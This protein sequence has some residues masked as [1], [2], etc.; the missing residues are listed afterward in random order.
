MRNSTL[1]GFVLM[2]SLTCIGCTS[3]SVSD[4]LVLI[5]QEQKRA[6]AQRINKEVLMNIQALRSSHKVAMHTYT[7]VYDLDNKE[8][9]HGDKITIA[10]LLE[11][12]HHATINIAPAKGA[13]KLKQLSLSMERAKAL[14]QYISYFN[15]EVTIIFSPKL[16]TDT[17]N[18]VVGA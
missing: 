12:K 16:S 9:N 2:L 6:N 18:L 11:K 15:K 10:K 1:A 3:T 4:Q 14:H 8:L 17:I 7:F 13:N 5:E